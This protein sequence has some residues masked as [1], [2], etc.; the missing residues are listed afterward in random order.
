MEREAATEDAATIRAAIENGA[1]REVIA[2]R[3]SRLG[4]LLMTTPTL[5]AFR[6]RF[7]KVRLTLLT[8]RYSF[9]LVRGA[10]FV[11][12]VTVFD[13]KEADLA[14]R[15]GRAL[16]Q[17]IAGR[18]QVL[19]ALRPRTELDAFAARAAIP[20]VYPR[21]AQSDRRDRH[22]VEQCYER[23]APLG[24]AADPGPL[25]ITIAQAEVEELRAR[26]ALNEPF[27]LFHPGCDETR[28]LRL[29]RGVRRRVWPSAHWVRLI[30]ATRD[31]FGL[32]VVLSAGSLL[33]GH[34]NDAIAREARAPARCLQGLS[35]RDLIGVTKLARACV[36]VDTGPLHLAT[37]VG[38]ALIGLY[39]PSPVTYTGPWAPGRSATTLHVDLPCMPCQGKNVHCPRNVCMEELSVDRVVEAIAAAL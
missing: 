12:E 26:L 10:S 22:V 34:I 14:G 18:F 32:Q 36:T 24:L 21:G 37:A 5:V 39:G 20:W 29:R 11:D 25:T 35:L 3:A 30:E 9:D 38:T 8:N 17:S 4:D 23:I 31:R 33:E 1:V 15:R 6:A 19:L 27:V 7:P 28:G 2:V 13:G 16:A